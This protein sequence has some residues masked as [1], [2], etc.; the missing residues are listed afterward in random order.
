MKKILDIH[1]HHAAPQPF[2]VVNIRVRKETEGYVLDPDQAY[3]VGIHPWDTVFD[4]IESKYEIL[5]SLAAQPEVVIIGEAGIDLNI[6]GPLFRQLNVFRHNVDLS[7]SL[8]KPLL[9]HDVKAHDVI[10]GAH[11]DLKPSLPWAIH[12]FR[13][14]PQ[15]AAMLLKAGLYLSFGPNFNSDTLREMPLDRILAETDESELNIDEV[16]ARL[17]FARGVPADEMT[18]I[19]AENSA[20]FLGC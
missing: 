16:I 13:Q 5:D 20:R 18:D 6:G 1:T 14:K 9:I 19:I 11:R 12:G 15:V 7:E 17:A 3:S 8:Q 4:A 2:G 10:V